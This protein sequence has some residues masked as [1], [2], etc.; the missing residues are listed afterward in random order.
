MK[1]AAASEP[2]KNVLEALSVGWHQ[3]VLGLIGFNEAGDA[4]VP[5][6]D[7]LEWDGTAWSALSAAPVSTDAR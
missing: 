6:Y 3:T 1:R 7:V 2:K 5:A 4:N